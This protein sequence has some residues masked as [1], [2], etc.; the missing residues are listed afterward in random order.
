MRLIPSLLAVLTVFVTAMYSIAAEPG[1]FTNKMSFEELAKITITTST[2]TAT[3]A[4]NTPGTTTVITQE[5]IRTSQAR[6]IAELM[7]IYVPNVQW[8]RHHWEGDHL[9]MRGIINDR[10]DKYLLLVNGRIMNQKSKTGVHSEKDTPLLADI[11]RIE[12]VSGPASA[13][14]G[15]GAIAMVVNII[16]DTPT[17][18]EGTEL[19]VKGGAI[20]EY[21]TFEFK[22]GLRLNEDTGFYLYLGVGKYTGAKSSHAPLVHGNDAV[23]WEGYQQQAGH[24]VPYDTPRDYAS[25]RGYEDIKIHLG[26]EH[27]DFS[28]WLRFTRGGRTYTHPYNV[29]YLKPEG[30]YTTINDYLDNVGNDGLGHHQG[31]T[32]YQQ[33]SWVTTYM[34]EWSE[35]V[36]VDYTLAFQTQDHIRDFYRRTLDAFREDSL[37]GQIMLHWYPAETHSVAFGLE[38]SYSEFGRDNF[39]FKPDLTNSLPSP[40][41]TSEYAALTEYQWNINDDW[42]MFLGGRLD[43]HQY[44][45]YGFSPR[46]ALI[47]HLTEED[48]LKFS[49]TKSLRTNNAKEMRETY[50]KSSGN[51]EFEKITNWELRWEHNY[52]D[53]LSFALTTYYNDMELNATNNDGRN[54]HVADQSIYGFELEANYRGDFLEL[55]FSHGYSKL[56]KFDLSPGFS[57]SFSSAADNGYGNDLANWSNHITKL[58]ARYELVT[59][60]WFVNASLRYYWGF[61]G[62]KD[63]AEYERD[64][65]NIDPNDT[66]VTAYDGKD[67]RPFEESIFLNMGLEYHLDDNNYFYLNGYN[68]L[69]VFDKDFNK[70]NYMA[71][72]GDFRNHATAVSLT[73]LMKF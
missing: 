56:D 1:R 53:Q 65:A 25:T 19:T 68:L 3:S 23:H 32:Q 45:D 7:D 17:T 72:S 34:Q 63:L 13:I 15:P 37:W 44:T 73:Y 49:V 18:F 14:Y 22:H 2:L 20:E 47:H 40:W 8:L 62:T 58:N 35:T 67:D 4:R 52:D 10:E 48:T 54:E 51:S 12:V 69:G 66:L 28:S 50:L 30:T 71:S 38:G 60:R 33:I 27:G 42:T 46:V 57:S 24:A 70:R 36:D 6:S 59:D 5:M 31:A 43:K 64:L 16:T 55:N 26:F 41:G 21:A 9:G 29:Q 61:P 39:S 11:Q